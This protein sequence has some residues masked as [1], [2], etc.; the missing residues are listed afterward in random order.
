[1][2]HDV[3]DL[4]NSLCV[5]IPLGEFEEGELMFPEINLVVE[6]KQGNIYFQSSKLLHGDFSACGKWHN[7]LQDY[8]EGYCISW[9][10]IE[11]K[12]HNDLQDYTE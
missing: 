11:G 4:D 1:L 2:H 6:L 10:K 7:D 9:K 8:T 5:V 3:K 12:W